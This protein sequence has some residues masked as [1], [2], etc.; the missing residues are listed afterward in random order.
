MGLL[1]LF[2]SAWEAKPHIGF[3]AKGVC[4]FCEARPILQLQESDFCL[5]TIDGSTI[6]LHFHN[7]D[8][9]LKEREIFSRDN[10]H[11]KLLTTDDGS[12]PKHGFYEYVHSVGLKRHL[13]SNPGLPVQRPRP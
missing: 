6:H 3:K 12:Y 7:F 5:F 2:S 11:D 1:F 13:E 8:V 4:Y 9:F 10:T